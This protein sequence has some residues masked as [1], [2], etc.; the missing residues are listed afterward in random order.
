VSGHLV[1]LVLDHGPTYRPAWAVA[2]VIAEDMHHAGDTALLTREDLAARTR[3]SVSTVRRGVRH[4]VDEGWVHRASGN[5]RGNAS[6]YRLLMDRFPLVDHPEKGGQGEPL[7]SEKGGQGE[8]LSDVKGVRVNRKGV[9][10]TPP[11]VN[12]T[13][14]SSSAYEKGGQGEPLSSEED[15]GPPIHHNPGQRPLW[16][17]AAEAPAEDRDVAAALDGLTWC[18][19]SPAVLAAVRRQLDR[20]HTP[21]AVRTYL[22]ANVAAG[23]MAGA[24][25][26]VESLVLKRLDT[27]PPP[28]VRHMPPPLPEPEEDRA[29]LPDAAAVA[30]YAAEARANMRNGKAADD[31]DPFAGGAIAAKALLGSFRR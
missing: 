3:L 6:V 26:A 5:G 1:G 23:V 8:P 28:K 19:H 21:Y 25:R 2:V 7:W 31:A 16:P 24:V 15:E 14:P 18:P 10:V 29:A 13:T 27:M 20:G 11:T 9:R 22:D 4:L 17:S 12:V 30:A